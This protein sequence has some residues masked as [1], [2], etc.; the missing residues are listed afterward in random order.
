MGW[1]A[2]RRGDRD[3]E[4]LLQRAR[5]RAARLEGE[6][7]SGIVV[8]D[9]GAVVEMDISDGKTFTWWENVGGVDRQVRSTYRG[10]VCTDE[11]TG[12]TRSAKRAG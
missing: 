5:N 9:E 10:G 6:I 3:A 12:Q 11:Y 1:R 4:R 2:H 7:A 8:M